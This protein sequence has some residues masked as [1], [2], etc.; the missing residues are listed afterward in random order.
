[1]ALNY[2]IYINDNTLSIADIVPKHP[3]KIQQLDIQDFDFLTFYK[4]LVKGSAKNYLLISTNPKMLFKT[5]KS[6]CTIINAAGGL[7]ANA[8]GEFLFIFRN[9]KWDLPKG[10]VEK[11][12]K[13]RLAAVREVEE[14]CG[15]KILTI[16]KRLCKT[17]H[18][19]VLNNKLVLKKTNW[20][21]MCVKAVPKLIPQKEEGITS[22]VWVAPLGVKAKT[23]NTYP[24]ILDVLKA[25]GLL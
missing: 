12:E 5:I 9:K 17:Y 8:H 4:N 16:G 18:V 20:Y 21:N 11:A 6:K 14:E 10:K 2:R 24:L 15:V 13:N 3:E 22:A 1:M 7:V 23:K 25:E 19:Y